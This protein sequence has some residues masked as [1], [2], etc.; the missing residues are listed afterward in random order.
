[1]EKLTRWIVKS[2]KFWMVIFLLLTVAGVFCIDKTVINY[3]LTQYLKADTMTRRSLTLMQEE[4]GTSEQ[5]RLM[6]ENVSEEEIARVCDELNSRDEILAAIHEADDVRELDG[7][8]YRLVTLTLT[9]CDS[10]ALV[11]ALRADYPG[12]CVGG[13]AANQLDIQKSVGQEVGLALALSVVIVLV[14]LLLTSHAWFEPVIILITLGISILINMGTNFLFPS[15]SFITF[16]VCAILQL[17]LSIDYAVMLLNGY[18]SLLSQGMHHEDAMVYALRDCMM[19]ISSS[20]MT[21]AA[22]LLSLLF[23]SF[24]I[25]F[26]IGLVLTKG[27]FISMVTVFLFMPGLTLLLRK[28]I[29]STRHKPLPLGGKNLGKAVSALRVPVALL[30]SLLVIFCGVAQTKNTYLFSDV[31][32]IS[33]KTEGG[34]IQAVFGVSD[35]LVL[36]VPGDDSE[37]SYT[38]QRQL[39][40]GM[41]HIRVNGKPVVQEV[42]AM[43]TTGAAALAYYT[44]EQVAELAGLPAFTVRLFFAANGLESPVRADRLL[45]NAGSFADLPQVKELK[46]ALDQAR[47]AF[48]G[49]RYARMLIDL[50]VSSAGEE[51]QEA[52]RQIMAMAEA[53]YGDDYYMTGTGMSVYDIGH[54]FTGDLRRVNLI[55]LAAIFLI[56]ALSFRSVSVPLLLVFVIEGAIWVSMAIS[57]FTAQPIFFISYLI[58]VSIQMGAT[59]D[60]GILLTDHYRALRA[61]LDRRPALMEALRLSLPTVLTSGIILVTAGFTVG[62]VCSIYYISSIGLLLSRGA[63]ISV[64][65]VLTLLPALLLIFDRFVSGVSRRG[66]RKADGQRLAQ[67]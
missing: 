58:C 18:H 19:P 62:K 38:M 23:M 53:M 7:S 14:M 9:P 16:A 28:A 44:P 34:R 56:V 59:I 52:I 2:R 12:A 8:E 67:S 37:E 40:S 35:P 55:T 63:L 21:T 25:G 6:F 57:K 13:A 60:Y 45:A 36:L 48:Q 30:L 4:F 26:D 54:A 24:T 1:M 50:N 31:D 32:N 46:D 66:K 42:T 64:I 43:V 27:I 51:A 17:A 3:D 47:S 41:V 39:I 65:L 61:S 49:E 22:G 10:S 29:H 15:V 20:A 11:E 33:E 5:L